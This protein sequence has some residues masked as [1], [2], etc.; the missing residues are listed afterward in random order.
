M[1]RCSLRCSIDFVARG[2]LMKGMAQF[3]AFFFN[4]SSK[5]FPFFIQQARAKEINM[6][7]LCDI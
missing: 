4:A 6:S 5:L 1:F 2:F 3:R 7:I